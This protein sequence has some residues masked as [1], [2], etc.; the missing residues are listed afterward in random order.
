MKILGPQGVTDNTWRSL[1]PGEQ[2]T[3]PEIKREAPLPDG[4]LLAPADVWRTRRDALLAHPGRRLGLLLHVDD[5]W[6]EFLPLLPR[7]ALIALNF[8]A[9]NDG[10]PFS[11][12]RLLRERHA[13]RGELRAVGD[14]RRD[15]LFFMRRCGFDAFCLVPE[16]Q[17]PQALEQALS[18]L[19]EFS[20]HY[21]SAANSSTDI[22]QLRR[23]H[24][25]LKTAK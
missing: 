2:E 20:V 10:R 16:Q 25:A 14:V 24:A 13:F 18:A 15:Q 17:S 9:F 3:A 11:T 12:A 8:P 6:E 19:R 22:F 21:Q 23:D 4:D 5:P 7:L 1:P